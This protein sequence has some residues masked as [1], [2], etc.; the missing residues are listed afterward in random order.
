MDVCPCLFC[1]LIYICPLT[2]ISAQVPQ[3]VENYKAQDAQGIS[4]AFLAVWFLG[5]STLHIDSSSR[6]CL[7]IGPSHESY[8]RNL[9]QTGSYGRRPGPV[10]LLGRCSP[11]PAVSILQSPTHS[12]SLHSPT[13]ADRSTRGSSTASASTTR[14]YYRLTWLPSSFLYVSKTA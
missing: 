6:T 1:P 12:Y 13:Y 4:L 8:W 10:L 3:L 5:D 2:Y 14:Q 7:I 11:D 9:G